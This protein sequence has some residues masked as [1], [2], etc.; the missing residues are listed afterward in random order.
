MKWAGRCNV[1]GVFS[2]EMNFKER[3]SEVSGA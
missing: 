1:G 2:L 3:R